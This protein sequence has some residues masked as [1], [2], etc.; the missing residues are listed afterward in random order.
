MNSNDD[1]HPNDTHEPLDAGLHA[2]FGP[3]VDSGS[4]EWNDSVVTTIDQTLGIHS[5]IS[6]RDDSD[7]HGPLCRPQSEEID[8]SEGRIGRYQLAGEIARGGVG[9]VVRG[10]DADLGR[11]V[12]ISPAS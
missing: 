1:A 6:L 3:S 7:G 8:E 12:A 11:D 5:R 2:A 9:V 10:R 4:S